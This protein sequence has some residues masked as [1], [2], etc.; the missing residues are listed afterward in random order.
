METIVETLGDW[1]GRTRDLDVLTEYVRNALRRTICTQYVETD[2]HGDD[3]SGD[4]PPAA[5]D[6]VCGGDRGLRRAVA[7]RRDRGGTP[8]RR[9]LAGG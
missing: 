3:L 2:T 4:L 6:A 7:G 9:A 5:A 8:Q 1:I